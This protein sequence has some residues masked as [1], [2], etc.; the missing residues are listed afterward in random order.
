[1]F[2]VI[3]AASL[4]IQRG[5]RSPT[6]SPGTRGK[7]NVCQAIIDP[8]VEHQRRKS[9]ISKSSPYSAST[10]SGGTAGSPAVVRRRPGCSDRYEPAVR[11]SA[12]EPDDWPALLAASGS[13][14]SEGE[15]FSSAG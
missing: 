5:P 14:V 2:G 7:R 11:G 8:G 10:G 15:F 9:G 4:Q 6:D 12:W 13:S 3:I 1:M